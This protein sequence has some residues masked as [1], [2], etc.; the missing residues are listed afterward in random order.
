MLSHY[1]KTHETARQNNQ[2]LNH[3]S[4]PYFNAADFGI[5]DEKKFIIEAVWWR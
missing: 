3:E 2:Q 4:N 5:L 1:N